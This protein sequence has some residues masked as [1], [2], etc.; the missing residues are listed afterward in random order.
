[1]AAV[2]TVRPTGH[3]LAVV[4]LAVSAFVIVTTEFIIVGLL[5]D[6]AHDLGVT[7]ATAGWL[8]TLFGFTVML[9]GLV[10]HLDRKAPFIAILLVFAGSNA[11]AA[12][13]P[14]IEVLAMARFLPAI[15]LT[16]GGDPRRGQSHADPTFGLR[17]CI[18]FSDYRGPIA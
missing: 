14:N 2:K 4:L 5:P 16:V 6:L 9:F 7:V 12:A 18:E 10:S 13:A 8:V 17:L 11:L 3:A 15:A 1:M